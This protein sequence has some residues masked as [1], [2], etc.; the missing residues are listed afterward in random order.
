[1]LEPPGWYS[2][3]Y[4]PHFDDGRS[5]QAITYRLADALPAN[6][7]SKLEE[8]SLGKEQRPEEIERFI[9]AGHGACA[10]RQSEN[11]AAVVQ[12]W[13]HFHGS[14]YHLHA[15]VV[16]PNH[17]H[18]LIEPLVGH[19]LRAIV[20]AWKSYTAKV[21]LKNTAGQR[22]ALPAKT[23]IWQADYW[24]RFIRNER[25]YHATVDYIHQN[26]VKAGLAA[27]AED[28]P[29]SSMGARAARPQ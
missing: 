25:H 16:M 8:Q 12:N 20:H 4:L 2:R 3:G 28:W 29:W 10:L 6:V 24:D 13:Q 7:V 27:K 14:H 15:W 21:I 19:D 11:A 26:P 18:V 22:P 23:R 1:M 9:D 17:V 5:L